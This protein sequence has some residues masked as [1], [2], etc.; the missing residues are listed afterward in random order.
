MY[1]IFALVFFLS[2][3]RGSQLS[4]P[5]AIE[6]STSLLRF[7]M[8]LAALFWRF[9]NLFD[10]V[11]PNTS[12]TSQQYLK[13]G[14]ISA[15]YTERSVSLSAKSF[16]R[17]RA[18]IPAVTFLQMFSVLLFQDKYWSIITPRLLHSWI[19]LMGL[20]SI[21]MFRWKSAVPL[22]I[23]FEPININSVLAAFK[24]SFLCDLLMNYKWVF[25]VCIQPHDL[26]GWG[27][28]LLEIPKLKTNFKLT[29]ISW[30]NSFH[31][32][33]ID[34]FLFDEMIKNKYRRL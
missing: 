32:W 28:L 7:V 33:L 26:K 4:S 24:L 5:K 23:G 21:L 2:A 31:F 20:L 15:L 13:Y 17:R 11:S 22:I 30:R 12:H 19:Y 9:C 25:E 10:C 29:R 1:I 6:W 8:I 34:I 14:Y 27:H 16:K 18:E 3:L